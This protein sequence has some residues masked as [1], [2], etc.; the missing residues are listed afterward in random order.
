MC[1][2]FFFFA[3]ADTKLLHICKITKERGFFFR[4]TIEAI[5]SIEAIEAI[6]AID[7]RVFLS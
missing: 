4:G 2:C 6:E 5:E 7:C 1:K 3:N